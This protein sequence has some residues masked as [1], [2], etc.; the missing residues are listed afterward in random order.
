MTLSFSQGLAIGLQEESSSLLSIFIAVILHKAV[1]AFSL[2]ENT[3]SKDSNILQ[4]N[5]YLK[6]WV[7]HKS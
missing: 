2:G 6:V 1:M 7:Q 5:L 4:D 3:I